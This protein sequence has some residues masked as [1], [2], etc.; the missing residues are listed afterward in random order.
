MTRLAPRQLFAA[1][2]V[3]PSVACNVMRHPQAEPEANTVFVALTLVAEGPAV[4]RLR[5]GF[6]DRVRVF[7]EGRQR[8]AAAD[9]FATR[10]YRFLGTVGLFD[11]LFLPLEAGDNEVWFALSEDF[12]GWGLMVEIPAGQGVTAR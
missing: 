5:F 2:L 7:L 6:S 1:A 8:F 11:E 10:D 4:V 3:L 12:G 9:E